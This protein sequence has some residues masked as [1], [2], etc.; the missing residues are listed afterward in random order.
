M[1]NGTNGNGGVA[2]PPAHYLHELPQIEEERLEKLFKTL[3]IDGNGRIDVR[4]LTQ[5]LHE[6]GVHQGYAKVTFD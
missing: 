2:P 1:V 3:D 6:S 5:S 4:D